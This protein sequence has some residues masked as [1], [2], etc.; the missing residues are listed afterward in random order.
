MQKLKSLIE[1]KKAKVGIIGLGY[2]GL[3]LVRLFASKGFSVIG[4][5]I[6]S[7][8]VKRINAG[9]SYIKSISSETI[10]T[11][12]STTKFTA[13][14]NFS[15]LKNA[16][17]I[18]ICVLGFSP[19]REDAGNKDFTNETIPKVVGGMDK[20]THKLAPLLYSHRVAR[21]V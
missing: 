16:D 11:L 6:D 3:P 17:A 2:V 13:T 1:S 15:Y 8:K 18:I 4:F 20:K 5:D 14:A 9:K 12:I 21:V 19:E 10:K 7:E